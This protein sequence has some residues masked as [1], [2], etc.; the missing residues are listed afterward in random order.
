MYPR[1]LLHSIIS[2]N[3]AVFD[4]FLARQ[5]HVIVAVNGPAIGA[6]VTSATLCDAI[7]AS[8]K[9][10]F[11]TP[12]G[13]LAVPPEG[14]SSVHFEHLMG[15]EKAQRMLEQDWVPSAQEAAEMGLITRVVEHDQLMGAAQ[16]LAEQW[17]AEGRHQQ[18]VSAMGFPDMKLL[19]EVNAKESVELGHAFM[20]EKFL[21]A[22]VNFLNSKGKTKLAGMFKNLLLTRPLWKLLM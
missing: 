3:Q 10:T 15:K 18:P 12:F 19:M 13:R 21:T 1:T 16:E 8:D 11:S 2:R 6:S 5:K 17:I 4:T 7:L 22:Q 20:G 9:A 14:C